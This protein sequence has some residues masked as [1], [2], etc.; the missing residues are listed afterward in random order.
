MSEFATYAFL[1]WL[2]RGIAREIERRDGA[3]TG[4]A[5]ASVPI[6]IG[7]DASGDR[8]EV[9]ADIEL[10]GPGEVAALDPRTIIRTVPK[11]DEDDAEPNYFPAVEFDQPDLPW[12]FTPAREDAART[13]LR[14]WL[15]LA[16]LMQDEIEAEAPAQGD[17]TLQAITVTSA[18]ALPHLSQ[19]WAWAHVQVDGFDPATET[20][21]GV[22]TGEPRRV[23][24]R[25]L[26]PRRLAPRT[27]YRAFVV[28][29]FERGR[30]AGLLEPLDDTIDALTPAWADDAS[31]VRLPV[32][33]SW[34]F[35]T[36]E[37]G[38]FETLV[39]RL[40]ARAVDGGVGLRDMDVSV[41]DPALPAAAGGPLAMEGALMSPAA[42]PTVWAAAERAA[43][44]A[45][46]ADLLN[47]QEEAL[48]QPGSPLAVAPPL[49]VRWQAATDRLD[50]AKGAEPLW[51]HD[52]NSDPR[53]RA[54]AGLG[55]EVVRRNDQQL[56]AEA[57]SQ[58]EGIVEA[59][60]EMR[61]AQ[62][63]REASL[64]LHDR[65][66]APL[67]TE[68]LLAVTAPLHA[69]FTLSALTAHEVLRR[70]PV[71]VGALAGG[72][73]RALRPAG[74][75]ARRA[76][77][78]RDREHAP[79]L[80]RLNHREVR[81][82]P[83]V[84]TPDPMVTRNR[85]NEELES[86]GALP[87]A[88]GGPLRRVLVVVLLLALLALF[89][90]AIV[91]LIIAWPLGVV[92]LTGAL[93][94]AVAAYLAWRGARER[95]R[96]RRV[97]DGTATPADVRG[98]TPDADYVPGASL[99][100]AWVA[101]PL[102]VSGVPAEE[103]RTA[104]GRFQT[105]F[106]D[107]VGEINAPPAP[108][109]ELVV[110]DLPG[111]ADGLLAR[112]DPRRT[113]PAALQQRLVIA[114]WVHW[115]FDDPLEPIM[116]APD[117]DTPMYEPLRELGQDW[118]MPGVERIPADTATLLLT[119][120]RFIEAYMAGLS[121]EMARELL[122][123]EFPTDQRGTYFRQF[124]DVRG[125][126]GNDHT[127]PAPE[128]LRD[129]DHIHGWRAPTAL[130]THSGRTP[131][132]R[133]GQLV[134]L[135]K[136]EVLRRYPSTFVYA[137]RTAVG[138]DRRR[139]LGDEEKFPVFEGRLDPDISFFGFDLLPKQARGDTDPESDQGWY[140]VLQ[141]QPTEPVFGLDADDGR[142][143]AL[144]TSWNDLSWAQLA[145]DAAAL[146]GLGYINLDADLPDT[147]V[148]VHTA[149]EPP[150]AWH[151]ETGRGVAGANGSDLAYITL[152]RPFRVAIHGSDM[153]PPE[154]AP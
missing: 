65:H 70:S 41:P 35:D 120:Q 47:R 78:V 95:N 21:D 82:R 31:H 38:D 46:L 97:L 62:A 89:V 140:F 16:I 112:M 81:A 9:T 100:G 110:A 133:A 72:M 27:R 68:T 85:L 59:N 143:A 66:F 56:M 20:L 88:G 6:T 26:A 83:P 33:W 142:Y 108:G 118:L 111:L 128:T 131:A 19:S 28:P 55:A 149:G 125:V 48:N 73:R 138:D 43:Y 49:W 64:R 54:G 116:A 42:E 115:G 127:A 45:A 98:M 139:T 153:L 141:E 1:P 102:S 24:S 29:V 126:V 129:I 23:R 135:I 93:S 123:H 145:T 90:L 12:R 15:A 53:L 99:P 122:Y 104:V 57:W 106:A 136:G 86:A 105:A 71:P 77:R 134:L 30:R 13:R 7:L 113:I 69:H 101:G 114:D 152:Q 50:P 79:L 150:L 148:V 75:I 92:V 96:R 91:L 76:G 137:V 22:V 2:R 18:T 119:N 4:E 36:G 32:Y 154:E 107:L 44:S 87:S 25:L 51:F 63:S 5:R 8:R 40:R 144:P 74:P 61:R 146:G 109:P 58:A 34:A 67:Q 132:P 103:V 52:L 37:A 14:P 11:P 84:A 151:A 147:S 130:G 10:F 3:M 60:A 121:H 39:R 94:A 117:I 124:W 80:A 17:G